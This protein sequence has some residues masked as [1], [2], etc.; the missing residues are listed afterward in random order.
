MA[1]A[2]TTRWHTAQRAALG[3][4]LPE[5][6][7]AV[8]MGRQ[9]QRTVEGTHRMSTQHLEGTPTSGCLH[10]GSSLQR[11]SQLPAD[12]PAASAALLGRVLHSA[13]RMLGAQGI[14][15]LC[16]RHGSLAPADTRLAGTWLPGM[17]LCRSLRRSGSLACSRAGLPM[18]P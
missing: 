11:S 16:S 2:R 3:Q 18:H 4:V 13:A 9:L 5:C 8:L 14:Q 1:T 12:R 10:S 6:P 7:R 15:S 17:G